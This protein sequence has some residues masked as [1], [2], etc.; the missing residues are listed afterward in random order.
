MS[1]KGNELVW[2]T[3]YPK[4]T[5]NLGTEPPTIATKFN[6]NPASGWT[7]VKLE[8]NIKRYE[9]SDGTGY[10]GS[11]AK[12][13][14]DNFSVEHTHNIALEGK[15]IKVTDIYLRLMTAGDTDSVP[16][17]DSNTVQIR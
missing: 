13:F 16:E 9:N 11:E 15:Y 1:L 10:N 8:Y 14:E 12:S 3:G 4:C 6:A 2:V 7:A 17:T 5:T